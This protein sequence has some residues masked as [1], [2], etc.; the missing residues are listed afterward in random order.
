ML[1][2]LVRL[3]YRE[4]RTGFTIPGLC[5]I[6]LVDR[7]AR[8]GRNPQTG[9]PIEIPARK[10]LKMRPVAKAKEMVTRVPHAQEAEEEVEAPQPARRSTEVQQPIFMTFKCTACGAEIEASTDMAGAQSQCP[11][12]SAPIRV[13]TADAI[14]ELAGLEN[15]ETMGAAPPVDGDE[16]WQKGSTIRI[17]LPDGEVP[18]APVKRT[19]YIKRRK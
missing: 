5:K 1:E 8:M 15:P 9:E 12:C 13:P 19:V 3:A 11:G 7:E 18:V 2:S 6:E 16:E 17:E 14:S 4:A 10:V